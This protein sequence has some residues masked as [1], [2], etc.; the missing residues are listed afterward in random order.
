M[1]LAKILG[2]TLRDTAVGYYEYLKLLLSRAAVKPVFVK[3][4]APH[5]ILITWAFPPVV[6][7]GVY[8]PLSFVRQAASLG[9]KVTVITGQST[10]DT[11]A[12]GAYLESKIPDSVS[13]IRVDKTT[14]RPSHNWFPQIDGGFIN[15][16]NLANIKLDIK[17][18]SVIL[19]SGPPF[20]SFVAGFLLSKKLD[21]PL[22][23]DYRDE[24]TQCPFDFVDI[25]RNDLG[26]EQKCLAHASRILVTTDSFREQ[27][28]KE[29]PHIDC[30]KVAVVKNGYQSEGE[31]TANKYTKDDELFTLSYLGYSAAHAHPKYFIDTL[32]KAFEFNPGLKSRVRINFIGKMDAE[33]KAYLES[34]G[35]YDCLSICPQ[36]D[37]AEALNLMRSSDALLLFNLPDLSRY[38]PGK[39]FDYVASGTDVLVF[40]HGGEIAKALEDA[41]AGVV[42][43][44]GDYRKLIDFLDKKRCRTDRISSNKRNEWLRAHDRDHIAAEMMSHL[45][46]ILEKK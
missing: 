2:Q 11:D 8:R 22:V 44:L 41:D 4:Q 32:S 23:L 7:G 17:S 29:F 26:W 24:W 21:V 18:P 20:C 12:A 5:L 46:T 35:L 19:A 30:S 28:A 42:I 45:N 1:L 37:K 10:Q 34:S 39:L 33:I 15:A 27:I 38:L 3:G 14:R 43:P 16:L 31:S 25:R 9:W 40:G 13:I 6:T 36:V